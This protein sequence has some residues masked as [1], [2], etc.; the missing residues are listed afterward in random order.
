[1]KTRL[2]MAT[3]LT[4]LLVL[5]GGAALAQDRGQ[6]NQNG[7]DRGRQQNGNNRGNDQNRTDNDRFNDHDRQASR[8]WY[9]GHAK[10]NERGFRDR[11]RLTSEYESQLREG[12]VL[13]RDLRQRSYSVPSDLRRRLAPAPRGYRY[14]VVGGHV[15]L[16][17]N[18]Y[19]VH[20][21]LTFNLH[22]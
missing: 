22:F 11:D 2:W 10:H 20:D 14:V 1:M 19:R 8:D 9:D 4:A 15:V 3:C 12:T 18:G 13:S 17:D 7:D 6:N 5:T 21:V 16:V